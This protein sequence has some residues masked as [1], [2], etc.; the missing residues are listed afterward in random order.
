MAKRVIITD[1][2][3]APY[4]CKWLEDHIGEP[5]TFDPAETRTIAHVLFHEGK[6]F[7]VLAVVA[8]NR[9]T[10]HT[11]DGSIASDGTKRWMSREF[12]WTVY[13]FAFRHADKSRMNF[14]VRPENA[15]AIA[16][17]TKLGHRFESVLED[18]NGDGKALLLFGFT[19]R[20]WKE[21]RWA[22]PK[23]VS[24]PLSINREEQEETAEE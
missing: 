11:V 12:S 21:S 7:E 10:T 4:F 18:A 2:R 6:R 13:D 1:Q 8:L 3:Y 20:Q 15:A 23:R 16:M 14:T 9:W 17:H 5:C 24:A 22:S 19:R